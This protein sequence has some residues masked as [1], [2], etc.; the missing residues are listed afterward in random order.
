MLLT[1]MSC[2][3]F[4]CSFVHLKCNTVWKIV[5]PKHVWHNMFHSTCSSYKALPSKK[6]VL[7]NWSNLQN[8]RSGPKWHVRPGLTNTIDFCL[9]LWRCQHLNQVVITG[10]KPYNMKGPHRVICLFLSFVFGLKA[11]LWFQAVYSI[12]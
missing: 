9:V 3:L 5:F 12:N 2:F 6:A 8:S 11:Q 7:C 10:W 4:F 1:K